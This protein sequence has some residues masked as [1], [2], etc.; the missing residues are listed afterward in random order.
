MLGGNFG[1]LPKMDTL[2]LVLAM[3]NSGLPSPSKSPLLTEKGL[4]PV[5]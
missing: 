1:L 4:S 2:P 3:A 5:I